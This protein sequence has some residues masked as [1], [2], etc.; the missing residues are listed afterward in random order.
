MLDKDKSDWK[1][2]LS[3]L[4]KYFDDDVLSKWFARAPHY[5][6]TRVGRNAAAYLKSGFTKIVQKEGETPVMTKRQWNED[7]VS[8]PKRQRNDGEASNINKTTMD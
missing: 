2:A 7:K 5:L 1:L 6:S 8:A 4:R 3:V